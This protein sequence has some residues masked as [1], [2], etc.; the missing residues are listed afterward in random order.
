M[1]EFLFHDWD[2]QFLGCVYR[3]I[4]GCVCVFHTHPACFWKQ[5]PLDLKILIVFLIVPTHGASFSQFYR[6]SWHFSWQG[7]AQPVVRPSPGYG[8]SS[9]STSEDEGGRRR[10]RSLAVAECW[11]RVV[12]VFAQNHY[13]D[14]IWRNVLDTVSIYLGITVI[15]A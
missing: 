10:R 14:G 15:I 9:P 5:N 11:L 8:G 4:Y 2:C 13:I 6:S 7:M 12:Q 1:Q 3:S